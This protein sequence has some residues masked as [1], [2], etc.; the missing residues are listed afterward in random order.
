LYCKRLQTS[1]KLIKVSL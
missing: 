1:H